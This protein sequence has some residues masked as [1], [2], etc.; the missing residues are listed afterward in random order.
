MFLAAAFLSPN[1]SADLIGFSASFAGGMISW[2]GQPT[3][4]LVGTNIGITSLT[5]SATTKN[6]GTY[7]V[8]AGDLEFS[9]GA[10]LG[11]S[12]GLSGETILNFASGGFFNITG[13]VPG[14]SIPN[15]SSLVTGSFS[16]NS[17]FDA[18]FGIFGTATGGGIDSV[19]GGLLSFFGF[20][21]SKFSFT[22]TISSIQTPVFGA[23]PFVGLVT[24]VR[25]SDSMNSSVVPEPAS[26]VLLGLVMLFC[27]AF[28][29][30]TRSS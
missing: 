2:D 26:I 10:F 20:S 29:L 27:C 23:S 13:G 9:T 19:G 6:A 16:S 4:A 14:A 5:G 3:H 8:T 15:G 24:G 25:I 30:R 21:N 28:R 1:A 17:S 11:T 18:L 22:A 7:S 12:T